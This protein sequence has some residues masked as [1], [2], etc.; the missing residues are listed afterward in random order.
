[1]DISSSAE[2]KAF[3]ATAR[4]GS[5]SAAAKLLGIRQ[6]T[7]SAHIAG[8]EKRFGVELFLRRGRGIQLTAFGSA[9]HEISNR[10]Y[11]GEQQAVQLL[12][13]ARSQ[14][15]GYLRVCAVGPYNVV[16]MVKSFHKKFP[17]IQLAVSVGDSKK[18][19][20]RILSHR[21]DVGVLL[22]SVQDERVHCVPYRR[23]K[24]V[25]FAAKTHPLA[26]RLPMQ[27]SELEGQEFVL[28]ERGSE[29]R[30]VFEAGLA[31][32]GVRIR[33]SIEMGSREAV[34]EAVA[35]GLGLGVVGEAAFVQDARLV[36]L[37]IQDMTFSTHVHVIVLE[38]R[39][40]APLIACFLDVVEELKKSSHFS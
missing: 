7:V 1:M 2:L 16:P 6:P 29:T 40:A 12:L 33:S 19:V 22:H 20:D 26:N 8:L 24:L 38:E 27:L 37:P 11:Q 4:S 25:V 5:M 31:T 28:R 39:R 17:R 13:G 35:Q 9:L 3:D 15:E 10:I 18:I 34:R 14:Y 36:A 32:H 21:D 30:A 23:Q